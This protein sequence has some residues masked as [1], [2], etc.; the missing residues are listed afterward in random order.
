[1]I[2][3]LLFC[4]EHGEVFLVISLY[5]MRPAFKHGKND[6]CRS[7]DGRLLTECEFELQT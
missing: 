4:G 7:S 5:V 3:W 1:M 6:L 2:R